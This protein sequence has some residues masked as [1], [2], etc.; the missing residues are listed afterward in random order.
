M[1]DNQQTYSTDIKNNFHFPNDGLGQQ[2]TREDKDEFHYEPG[3]LP[4]VQFTIDKLIGEGVL[5]VGYT[6]KLRWVEGG[7]EKSPCHSL[8]TAELEV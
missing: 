4:L 2:N 7:P 5:G 3:L 8:F 1:F 6:P